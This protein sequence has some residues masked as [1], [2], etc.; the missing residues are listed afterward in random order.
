MEH[1]PSLI[2]TPPDVV[3]TH[4]PKKLYIDKYHWHMPKVG[5]VAS[6]TPT[7]FDVEDHYGV[8]RGV[9]MIEAFGQA[10]N[11]S[12]SA[13]IE[14]IKQNC[15]FDHLKKT[16]TPLFISVGQVNFRGYLQQGETFISIGHIL[17]YKFR[18][19]TCEG[20]IYK[21]PQGLDLDEYFKEFTE[22]RLLSYDIDERFELV[23]ELSE[24]V[25]KGVKKDKYI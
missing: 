20:R 9:D 16:L 23:A 3:M 17:F 1:L 10:S 21:V 14:S 19:M 6:Y 18:Q 8:F 24:I 25:G 13:Y 4:G 22:Q 5:I 7:A 11:G 12:C 2:G 15:T